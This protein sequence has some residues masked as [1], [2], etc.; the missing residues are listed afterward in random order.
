MNT[1]E[2]CTHYLDALNAGD[3]EG[4]LA[5]FTDEAEVVSPLYGVRPVREFFGG[6]FADTNRSQT[7]LVNIFE[8]IGE[9]PAVALQ[10]DYRW[11]LKNGSVVSFGCVDVFGLAPGGDRFSGLAIH[12]D[13]A[14]LRAEFEAARG[15]G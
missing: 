6:L 13:T 4:V 5:L 15:G 3:L 10:F 12:Y 7:R 2:L 9:T 1:Q 8:A 14:P 11:T